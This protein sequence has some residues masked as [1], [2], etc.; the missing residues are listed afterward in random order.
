MSFISYDIALILYK[1]LKKKAMNAGKVLL[2]VLAGAAVG[3][4]LGILFAPD[5]GSETRKK[6]VQKGVDL[7]DSVK[8]RIDGFADILKGNNGKV[9][10]EKV[11]SSKKA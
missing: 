7:K 6:I 8:D 11:G 2:G 3:A 9:H 1:Q 4:S 5:K 10:E